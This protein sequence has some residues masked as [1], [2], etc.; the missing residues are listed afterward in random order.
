MPSQIPPGEAFITGGEG[1][2]AAPPPPPP[3]D[4]QN[5]VKL[6]TDKNLANG[7]MAVLS[8]QRQLGGLGVLRGVFHGFSEEA[9]TRGFPSPSFDGF[10]FVGVVSDLSIAAAW[11]IG[12]G[13]PMSALGRQ[14]PF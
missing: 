12:G 11:R 5:A 8:M 3:Q 13:S 1:D 7:F 9:R 6:K 14:R 4:T 2:G 10:G